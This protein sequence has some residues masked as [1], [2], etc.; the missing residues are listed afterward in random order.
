MTWD[1]L[2]AMGLELP[3]TSIGTAYGTPAVLVKG[4]GFCRVKEDG[5][6]VVFMTGSN[7]EQQLLLELNPDLCFI[8]DH[9][10]G[11]QAIL[12]RLANLTPADARARLKQ[13]WEHRAPPA[14][15]KAAARG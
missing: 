9:Y 10:R 12:A 14:V 15:K 5:E 1:E 3:A 2:A 6:T 7:A 11:G 13:G 4:K 8:T